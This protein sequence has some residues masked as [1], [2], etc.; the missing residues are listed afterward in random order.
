MFTDK[1]GP[2]LENMKPTIMCA[3]GWRIHNP[4]FHS[5][6]TL[7]IL[8]PPSTNLHLDYSARAPRRSWLRTRDVQERRGT[9]IWQC[10]SRTA[11]KE[12]QKVVNQRWI[13]NLQNNPALTKVSICIT[14]KVG[15]LSRPFCGTQNETLR[16]V[17]MSQ[18]VIPA[19]VVCFNIWFFNLHCVLS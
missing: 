3:C 16:L 11:K 12:D 8:P 7:T 6:S 17:G 13:N 15:N 5:L 19:C 4:S 9:K 2:I 18:A 14:T 10:L 1:G